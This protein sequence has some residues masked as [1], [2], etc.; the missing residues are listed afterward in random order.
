MFRPPRKG[1]FSEGEG[2]RV[3]ATLKM[4]PELGVRRKFSVSIGG[5][6][7]GGSMAI[8]TRPAMSETLC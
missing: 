3:L 8:D 5:G 2:G 7:G 4:L 6:E 1:W